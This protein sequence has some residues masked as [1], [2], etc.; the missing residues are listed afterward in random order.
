MHLCGLLTSLATDEL[1][2]AV[3]HELQDPL[4]LG[5]DALPRWVAWSVQVRQ[6]PARAQTQRCEKLTFNGKQKEITHLPPAYIAFLRI[7]NPLIDLVE[8]LKLK[9]TCLHS[10]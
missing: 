6:V 5:V 3:L 10:N 7:T 8:S 4:V 2:S 1:I 9:T